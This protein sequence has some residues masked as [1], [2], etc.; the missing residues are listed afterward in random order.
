MQESK[1]KLLV[2]RFDTH[3]DVSVAIAPGEITQEVLDVIGEREAMALA[4][5]PR[6][7]LVF[8]AP[9]TLWNWIEDG[10]TV[11]VVRSS[12]PC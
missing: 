1:K 9:A 11:Y 4:T 10:Q 3:E 2:K 5:G 6:P 8:L 12:C 7:G